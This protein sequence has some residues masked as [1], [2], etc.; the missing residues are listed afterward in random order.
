MISPPSVEIDGAK[1]LYSVFNSGTLS[2][3]ARIGSEIDDCAVRHSFFRFETS[4]I[5]IHIRF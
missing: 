3:H 2:T 1:S 5:E 4:L